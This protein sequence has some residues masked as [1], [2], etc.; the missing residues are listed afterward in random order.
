M[1]YKSK[2]VE[3]TCKKPL[4]EM[5]NQWQIAGN[6]N[7]DEK[8]LTNKDKVVATTVNKDIEKKTKYINPDKDKTCNHCKKKG[9]TEKKCQKKHPEI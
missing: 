3:L 7:R 4:K 9:H 6:K 2:G 8:D 1:I 5:H